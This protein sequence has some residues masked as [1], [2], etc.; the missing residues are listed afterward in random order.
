LSGV[1]LTLTCHPRDSAFAPMTRPGTPT[2][3]ASVPG[4]PS[5]SWARAS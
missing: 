5:L 3:P 1:L 2:W 4:P